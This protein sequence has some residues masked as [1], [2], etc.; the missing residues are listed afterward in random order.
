MA[1]Y[2]YL[3]CQNRQPESTYLVIPRVSSETRKYIP[4]G[5]ILPDVIASDACIIIPDVSIYEFAILS[6]RIHMVWVHI[7]AGRLK[8]DIRYSPSVYNN[9]VWPSLD[10]KQKAKIESTAQ[11]ILDVRAQFIESL[12]ADLYAPLTMPEELLK[13]HKANDVAVCETYGFDKGISEEEIVAELM[14]MYNKITNMRK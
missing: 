8:S 7:V 2:P 13:A 1:D 14:N 9:F 10:K 12:L 5:F 6:S 4:L 3:F 11:R